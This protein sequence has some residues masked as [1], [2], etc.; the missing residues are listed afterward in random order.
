VHTATDGEAA[1]RILMTHTDE[2]DVVFMDIR[3]PKV[4]W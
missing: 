2:I 4:R 1:L 3:L